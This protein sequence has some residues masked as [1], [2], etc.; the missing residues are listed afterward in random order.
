V[1]TL[2]VQVDPLSREQLIRLI[3]T[4]QAT[5]IIAERS[6]MQP[7]YPLYEFLEIKSPHQPIEFQ[8][9]FRKGLLL[10]YSLEVQTE[11]GAQLGLGF[12]DTSG[13]GE[14]AVG[15]VGDTLLAPFWQK[16]VTEAAEYVKRKE[17]LAEGD[18]LLRGGD[19]ARIF[20]LIPGIIGD[21]GPFR[22]PR[23]RK[24]VVSLLSEF[25][26]EEYNALKE[27]SLL[28]ALEACHREL[29]R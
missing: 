4:S 18:R 25:Y 22:R 2:K 26:S 9:R 15:E 16:F 28:P 10:L 12:P 13:A 5:S 11:N 14:K 23:L 24:K 6:V 3:R 7:M 17:V 21:V 27:R 29:K 20:A 1:P 8:M 19:L